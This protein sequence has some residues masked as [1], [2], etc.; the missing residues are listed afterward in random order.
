MTS[1]E[2]RKQKNL[3]L[4]AML[5]IGITGLV[6]ILSSSVEANTC[7]SIVKAN[8]EEEGFIPQ[9]NRINTACK[10]LSDTLLFPNTKGRLATR[11][12]LADVEGYRT[13]HSAELYCT[14]KLIEAI[15]PE[16]DIKLLA[17]IPS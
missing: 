4:G 16:F 8:L 15:K 5:G 7:E 2:M 6:T 9:K 3:L 17:E 14:S 1:I 10:E 13:W 11:T 12:Y